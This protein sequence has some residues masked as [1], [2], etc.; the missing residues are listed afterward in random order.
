[1]LLKSP[2]FSF[3]AI[4]TLALGIGLNTSIFS[5]IN[6]LFLRDLPFKEPG[7]VVHM[8]SNARQRNLLELAVSA[9]RFQHYRDSQTIF[10]G[11]GAENVFA[12]TLTGLGDPVQIF[13]GRVTPSYFDVLGVRPVRGRNFLP[14]EEE[15]A[16]V[17]M[18]TENF[19]QKRMGGDPRVIGRSV[20]LDGV[21]H[22]IVG[23]LPNLPFSWVGPSAEVWTAKPYMLPGI[24]YERMMRGTGFLRVVG[25]LKPGMTIEQARAALPSLEQSYRTQNPGKIDSSS[26]LTL[27]TLS[28]DVTGNLRPAFAT[29]FAAVAFVLLIAC[30]NVA[31][32]LLVRFSGRRREIALR[33]AIGASRTGIV[34]LFVFES[35]LVSLLA[36]IVGA[37]LAWQLVPLVPK[38]AANF[39]PFDPNTR[40]KLS[41]PVL[42]FTVALSILTGPLMG[43][44]PAF[45]SSHG[46]LVDG[47]KEGG[48]GVSGSVRQQR[49]RKILVGA[50][51]ALSVTLLAGAALLIT[52]FVRLNQ[53]KVGYQYRNVWIGFVTL[54]TAQ[55]SDIGTRQRFVERLLASLRAV[56]GFESVTVSGDIPLLPGGGNATLYSRADG[57][58][59]PVDKR[60]TAPSHDVSPGYF[61]TWGIPVLAG[62]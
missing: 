43:I 58:V 51:V 6:D 37:V 39:L 38:M 57:E 49:F 1:M 55:Y 17:A 53:Q 42:G 60:A 40:V 59:L 26:T 41:F 4:A 14:E 33:M 35:L 8:Y 28:E 19:W 23:I 25:R 22:T 27:K 24:S 13:G 50:Q 2:G 9:P 31:N 12:F 21:P 56:P 61:K 29:L 54:P 11:F 5:L 30:S 20:T 44:Y 46:D 32:L 7:R 48:R 15:S 3:I 52:S 18:V 47:L 10:D 36:G 34:R 45:Q 16:D 62:R